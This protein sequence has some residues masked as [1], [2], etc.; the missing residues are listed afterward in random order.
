MTTQLKK[1]YQEVQSR[2]VPTGYPI[3]VGRPVDANSDSFPCVAYFPHPK[4][5]VETNE[6][7]ASMPM[8]G[9]KRE[10]LHLMVK[11]FIDADTIA[12]YL[13]ELEDA[14]EV[15][16]DALLP[17]EDNGVYFSG[18]ATDYPIQTHRNAG[19]PTDGDSIAEV[20]MTIA[21]PFIEDY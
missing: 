12:D 6:D 8:H 7:D 17:E 20:E 3:V 2:L 5:G 1:I 19:A 9:A 16:R 10:T 21:I 11:V 13:L 4:K 15:V 14:Y 18:L